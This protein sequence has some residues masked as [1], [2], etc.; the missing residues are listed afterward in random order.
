MRVT[1]VKVIERKLKHNPRSHGRNWRDYA[2]PPRI[3]VFVKENVFENL[4]NRR[5]RPHTMYKK[6]AVTPALEALGLDVADCTVA[7]KQKAGCDCGCSP[8]FIVTSKSGARMMP[9]SDA[10]VNVEGADAAI[11]ADKQ[12]RTLA[13]ATRGGVVKPSN[14][15]ELIRALL[16]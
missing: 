5:V 4:S 9:R 1:E 6:F 2:K 13:I 3:Y 8:A 7:W 16:N 10:Y 15:N 12:P 14:V 11:D